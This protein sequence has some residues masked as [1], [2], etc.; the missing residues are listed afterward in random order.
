MAD[1]EK[2]LGMGSEIEFEGK[3]WRMAPFTY[4]IQALYSAWLKK[5]AVMGVKEQR[6]YLSDEEYN[7]KMDKVDQNIAA[8]VYGFGGEVCVKSSQ[9]MDG[10][11]ELLYITLHKNHPDV[12]RA[13]IDR[14]F[15]DK[16][17][18][19]EALAAIQRAN[20]DPLSPRPP[21]EEAANSP[22]EM[23]APSSSTNPGS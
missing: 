1:E 22:S 3:T 2:V 5:R 8:G 16:L 21:K 15:M 12:D 11:K 13:F 20:S 6:A 9:S 7:A 14:L 18:Q 23:C 4:E 19:A 10:L 17:I